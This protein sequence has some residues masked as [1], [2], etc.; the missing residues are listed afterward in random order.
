MRKLSHDELPPYFNLYKVH[1]IKIVTP[2]NLRI[3]PLP[4][5]SINHT[6]AESCLVYQL[7]KMKNNISINDN[8]ILQKIEQRTHSHSGFS[9]YVI[10]SMLDKYSFN[11]VKLV[12]HTCGRT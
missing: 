12:C 3:H 6:Y 10:N 5:P 4:A 1:L 8:L 2:Y 7:V 11:C 9:K